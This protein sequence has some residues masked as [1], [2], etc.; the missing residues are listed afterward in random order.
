V[1][2][3]ANAATTIAAHRRTDP[4]RLVQSIRGELDW[5]VMKCLEKDRNRR[6]ETASSLAR[7]I[8]HYLQD[9]PVQACPPSASYRFRKFARRNKVA[10]S[11]MMLF[12]GGILYLA[13]SNIALKRERDA[14][15]TAL[16]DANAV[17]YLLQEMLS[18]SYPDDVKDAQYTV[19]E[20]L[21]EF[22]A[23]M[24]DHL[25]G[26]PEVEAAIRSVIGKAYWRLR[27]LD[28]AEMN[29]KR[30]LELRRQAFG[31]SD[32][33]VAQ[34][35][36][37]YADNLADQGQFTEAE[38]CVREALSI[39]QKH[40]SIKDA[41]DACFFLTL[42]QLRRGDI[43]AYR[44][45]CNVLVDLPV[46][47]YLVVNNTRPVWPLCLAP[48][49]L[50][51]MS[52]LVKRAEEIV[53]DKSLIEGH[54]GPLLMGAA[55]FRAGRYR[56]AHERLEQSIAEYPTVPP[57]GFDTLNY[58]RLLF[59]MTQWRLGRRDEARQLFAETKSAV[60]KEIQA[61][62]TLWGRRTTLEVLR[63]EAEALIRPAEADE[64][65]ES[66]NRSGDPD[67]GD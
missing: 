7:D 27:V 67:T 58:Q 28:K 62:T 23:K 35:L 44:K 16:A 29:L 59:A 10:L 12:L 31:D 41:A 6:Y 52:R 21:D 57:H 43:D 25:A 61:P 53:A 4:R 20:L 66:E 17:S 37:E 55:I 8:E 14:K 13:Y 54:W 26:R 46:E 64:A 24:S 45:T 38:S 2:E 33:R 63:N 49:A 36:Y 11:F 65:V 34:S 56:E 19:R 60:E 9:K 51:D 32:M 30:A 50:D 3:T 15:T 22:S 1:R 47:S 48:D 5:I 40:N 42:V 18:S 39:F